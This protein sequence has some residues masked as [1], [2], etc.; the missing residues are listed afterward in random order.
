M[1]T[2]SEITEAQ[3]DAKSPI[4]EALMRGTAGGSPIGGMRGNF[5]NHEDR[6]TALEA[7]S[8]GGGASGVG[9]DDPRIAKDVAVR[10]NIG[11]F[12]RNRFHVGSNIGTATQRDPMAF[13][14]TNNDFKARFT[15]HGANTTG[16]TT[17]IITD[18]YL[19]FRSDLD[20]NSS[21]H[22]IKKRGENFVGIVVAQQTATVSS[23][24]RILVDGVAQNTYGLEDETGTAVGASQSSVGAITLNQRTRWFFGLNPDKEEVI[25]IE[26]NDG[27]NKLFLEAVDAGFA[28]TDTTFSIDHDLLISAGRANIRGG[29]INVPE[30][31]VSFTPAKHGGYTGLVGVDQGSTVRAIEGPEPLMTK[32]KP[33]NS[34]TFSSAVTQLEV[35]NNHFWPSTGFCVFTLPWGNK[36][37]FSYTGKT[38]TTI[39]TNVHQHTFDGIVWQSQPQEDFTPLDSFETTGSADATGDGVI[40]HYGQGGLEITAS[41]KFID[42]QIARNGGSTVT[43]A[44]QIIEGLYSGERD[45]MYLGDAIIKAMQ[46]AEPLDEGRYIAEYDVNSQKWTLGAEGEEVDLITFLFSTG[47]NSANSVHTDLGYASTD[48][49]STFSYRASG[50]ANHRIARVWDEGEYNGPNSPYHK[51]NLAPSLDENNDAVDIKERWGLPPIRSDSGTDHVLKIYPPSDSIGCTVGFINFGNGSMVSIQIDEGDLYYTTYASNE[52]KAQA[53]T[54]AQVI[55]HAVT[56]PMGSRSIVVRWYDRTGFSHASAN[57]MKFVG[58]RFLYSRA[59]LE[60]LDTD[61]AAIKAV[62]VS[63]LQEFKTYYA[64]DYTL[65]SPNL[66]SITFTGSWTT[67]TTQQVFNDTLRRTSTSG[68]TMDVEFTIVG[69]TGGISVM[70]RMRSVGT[71]RVDY[72]LVQG[73]SASEVNTLVDRKNNLYSLDA[74]DQDTFVIDGL[75]TGTYT[76]RVKNQNAATLDIMAIGIYDTTRVDEANVVT[77]VSDNDQGITFPVNVV[78]IPLVIDNHNA[79]IPDSLERDQFM[80]GVGHIGTG[81]SDYATSVSPTANNREDTSSVALSISYYVNSTAINANGSDAF[82]RL[83]ALAK[84]ICFYPESATTGT[85]SLALQPIINGNNTANTYA[86]NVQ[87]KAGSAPTSARRSSIPLFQKTFNQFATGNMSDAVTIPFTDT[88]G[89]RVGQK[90]KVTADGQTTVFDKI[91]SITTNTSITM[92]DGVGGGFTNYTT[93]NN[94]RVN[95]EGFH[96]CLIEQNSTTQNAYPSAWAYELMPLSESKAL[97]RLQDNMSINDVAVVYFRNV[98]NGLDLNPPVFKNGRAADW[99]EIIPQVFLDST[100]NNVAFPHGLKNIQVTGVDNDVRLT[101]VR[102]Y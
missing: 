87:V 85:P 78:K 42:Y 66:A 16:D 55:T 18:A 4:D 57:A 39:T 27:S 7:T 31:T 25:Q 92:E 34:I 101:A 63:P 83:N 49:S 11:K 54:K 46:A 98:S 65:S 50:T 45:V 77:D 1:A 15:F 97:T 52:L 80:E 90:I 100:A 69:A 56:W 51:Y 84:S 81:S 82:W 88:R 8:G 13:D 64:H 75:V 60:L 72:Y 2:Y 37:V 74:D 32:V 62:T 40:L 48:I 41:N 89:F 73:S 6:I 38:D 70:T 17:T 5:I 58:S 67:Q 86:E 76:L 53:N 23:N 79:L 44:A 33:L 99:T 28:S 12:F 59:P 24:W 22:F 91:A 102:R 47:A 26:N 9:G 94:L 43:R 35:K 14:P 71:R 3:S 95:Y 36:H 68:D 19:G 30:T 20:S 61:E 93:A 29:S 96:S 10:D 21:L